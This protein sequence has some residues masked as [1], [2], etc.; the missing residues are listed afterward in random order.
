MREFIPNELWTV[1]LIING[2]VCRCV[3]ISLIISFLW[4]YISY[5]IDENEFP[6]LHFSTN[7]MKWLP[8]II[9]IG[10]LTASIAAYCKH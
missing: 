4:T 6:P 7:C 9:S 1:V 2:I 5:L 10:S 8:L 3:I